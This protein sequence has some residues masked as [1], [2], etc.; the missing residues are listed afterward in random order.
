MSMVFQGDL[1]RK[2]LKLFEEFY[3]VSFGIF[4]SNPWQDYVHIFALNSLTASV[5][6]SKSKICCS[7]IISRVLEKH[8][9]DCL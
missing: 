9:V 4:K 5:R 1:K 7:T 2:L 6:G 8:I 3:T